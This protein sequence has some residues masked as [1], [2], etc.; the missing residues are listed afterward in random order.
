M[1]ITKIE[2]QKN[3][4]KRYSVFIDDEFAFGIDELDL[5]YYK[6]SENTQIDETKYNFIL[7]NVIYNKAKNKAVKYISYQPRTEKEVTEKLKECEYSDDIIFRVIETMKKY[8]YIN[9]KEY[10][11]NFLT[12][13]LNLKGYGIFKISF[14]LKQKGISDDIINDIIENTELNENKRALEVLEKKLRGKKISDYKE[15]QK[16]YNFLLRRGFSYDVI[17]E[18]VNNFQEND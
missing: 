14:D 17:K 5:L 13:K 7:E 10:A 6:L 9:D 12:S 15:K 11:K 4:L 18:A 1:K 3:N 16:L 8:N 2:K